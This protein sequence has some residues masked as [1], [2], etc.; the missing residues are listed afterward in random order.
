M[1]MPKFYK[2]AQIAA[3]LPR[4]AVNINIMIIIKLPD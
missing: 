4:D 2:I 1:V 3:T